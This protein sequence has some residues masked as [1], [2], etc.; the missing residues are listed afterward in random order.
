VAAMFTDAPDISQLAKRSHVGIRGCKNPPIRDPR[1]GPIAH[2]PAT[3]KAICTATA[4]AAGPILAYKALSHTSLR[5]SCQGWLG[6]RTACTLVTAVFP[7]QPWDMP[8][9]Q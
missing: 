9:P 1:L 8:F 2:L 5:E 4:T 6:P 3:T 7:L